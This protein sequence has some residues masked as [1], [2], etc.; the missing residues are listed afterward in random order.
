MLSPPPLAVAISASADIQLKKGL[1]DCLI[2]SMLLLLPRPLADPIS[3]ALP[4]GRFTSRPSTAILSKSTGTSEGTVRAQLQP[5]ARHTL[6]LAGF[7]V[8]LKFAKELEHCSIPKVDAVG[9]QPVLHV[10][11]GEHFRASDDVNEQGT[12]AWP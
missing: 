2:R 4:L 10:E 3:A 9:D 6:Q 11:P 5:Q 8:E 7:E 1:R 12:F